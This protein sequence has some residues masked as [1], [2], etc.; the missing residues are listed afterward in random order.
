MSDADL[1]RFV[2]FL[3]DFADAQ[4]HAKE[5]E[6]LFEAM[7]RHGFSRQTGPVAVM[8]AEH[9]QGRA[10]VTELA[11]VAAREVWSEPDK[12][13]LIRSARAFTTLLRMHIQK[14]DNVL[15]VIAQ[16]T[17]PEA[18]LAWVR[19]RMH[20]IEQA[21]AVAGSTQRLQLLGD[22]LAHRYSASHV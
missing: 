14:E 1:S 13:H 3:R 16:R 6:V 2:T 20:E 18:T 10:L 8:L 9:E 4:H 15:Y 5:E 17:L 22:Q 21:H 7:S 11:D 12:N 19:T